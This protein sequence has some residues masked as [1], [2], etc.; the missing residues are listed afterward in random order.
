VTR[1][2]KTD[3]CRRSSNPQRAH[4]RTA[5]ST[6]V[7]A[8]LALSLATNVASAQEG[9]PDVDRQSLEDAWWTGPILAASASTLPEGRML[10]EPYVFDV[11]RYGRY[12]DD[13]DRTDTSHTHFFGSLTYINYGLTDTLTVGLI[14]TF[15]YNDAATGKDSS[16]VGA[17]DLTVQA[18]YRLTQFREGS[19]VPTISVVLQETLPT[20]KYDELG[21]RPSDGLGS[22]AHTTT[23]ALYSQYY[24]WMPNGR[25][26]RSRFNVAY[27][28]SNDADVNGV[29][30]YGTPEEFR[31]HGSPG[32]SITINSSWEYSIT[33]NWVFAFDVVYQHSES[34]R[35]S[36]EVIDP[37]GGPSQRVDESFGSSWQLGLAPA[38]EYNWNSR[39]GVIVGARWFAAG[40]NADASITP[41]A[42]INMVY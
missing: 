38:I 13:G 9:A 8:L 16:G 12:D 19:R 29:S 28:L 33:R 32:D 20:A 26:L 22:G 1:E 40:R 37:A 2:N 14:P 41:V 27:A 4:D 21:D 18:Q 6:I 35:V 39:M 17:G 34:T 10:I 42:A 15:G 11:R 30:V 5:S 23:L 25:I 7:G 31:G 24:F 36:G 3:S